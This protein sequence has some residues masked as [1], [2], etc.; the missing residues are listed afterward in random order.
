MLEEYGR[1]GGAVNN[2]EKPQ[3]SALEE[4][5]GTRN[6]ATPAKRRK[7][8]PKDPSKI[9]VGDL[10]L[11]P[12][13]EF[14]E[15]GLDVRGLAHDRGDGSSRPYFVRTALAMRSVFRSNILIAFPAANYGLYSGACL[16]GEKSWR[17][18]LFMLG[19]ML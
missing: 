9:R 17:E 10:L 1:P 13:P 19:W 12:C 6:P 2:H 5:V 3:R 8:D 11:F 16:S 4:N 14:S 18:G 15:Q 7:I